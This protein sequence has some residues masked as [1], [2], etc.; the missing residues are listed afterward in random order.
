MIVKD[1]SADHIYGLPTIHACGC[2]L[3]LRP[4]MAI[5][6]ERATIR[7]MSD[8]TLRYAVRE[9][10]AVGGSDRHFPRDSWMPKARSNESLCGVLLSP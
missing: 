10:V 5:L 3:S 1:E 7:E 4:D 8:L 2:A 9:A 6:A